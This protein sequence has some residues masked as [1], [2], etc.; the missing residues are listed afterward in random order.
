[1]FE[2]NQFY[3]TDPTS[4]IQALSTDPETMVYYNFILAMAAITLIGSLI[5][6]FIV[7][8]AEVVGHVPH[9]VRKLCAGKKSHTMKHLAEKQNSQHEDDDIEMSPIGNRSFGNP[10]QALEEAKQKTAEANQRAIEAEK[11]HTESIEQ[12][13]H[14]VNQMKRLKKESAHGKLIGKK[15]S[16]SVGL[17]KRK[18]GK[19]RKEM[20]QRQVRSSAGAE[21]KQK[22][23]ER[24]N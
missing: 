19:G 6:Y 2:S 10:L 18:K 23:Q 11:N 21:K 15:K 9:W 16:R 24:K 7:F 5:Y 12:Q 17:V 13:A 3:V 20:M 1:M 14:L 8:L 22:S 4:G